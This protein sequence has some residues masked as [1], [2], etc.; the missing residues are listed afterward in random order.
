MN[1]RKHHPGHS[2][3]SSPDDSIDEREW[4]AQE[5]AARAERLG[6]S[7]E[8]DGDPLVARYRDVSRALRQPLADGPPPDFASDLA[9]QVAIEGDATGDRFERMALQVMIA[10]LGLSLGVTC[11]LLGRDWLQAIVYGAPE[12]T[13]QWT[14][15]VAL[16]A[17]VHWVMER[18]RIR[19]DP[20]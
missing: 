2:G 18:W 6:I 12:G 16:C 20:H 14:A 3:S 19:R 11:V 13:L 4:L 8:P 9:R 7:S 10:L 5:R 17:G 15:L 1:N